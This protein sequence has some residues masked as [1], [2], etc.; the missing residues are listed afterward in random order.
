MTQASAVT[1]DP[2]KLYEIVNGE[3]REKEMG[4]ARHG[5]VGSRLIIELGAHVKAHGLGG[6]Y[7]PDTS[8]QVGANERIP[9]VAFVA[10]GRIPEAGEP[11]GIWPFAPDLAVEVLSPND[12]HEKVHAKMREYFAAG[13]RQ[14]WLVSPE[15][16]TVTLYR[17]PTEP[18]VLTEADAL[19]CE[20]LFP[21]FRC[22]VADLFRAPG[23]RASGARAGG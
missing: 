21:G 10:A 16:K 2:D 19:T 9:D 1:L 22:P 18:S 11:D 12:L 8:F 4:G 6:I 3:P 14:V 5:G 15:F 23:R 7:G 20:E 13:V 17:S